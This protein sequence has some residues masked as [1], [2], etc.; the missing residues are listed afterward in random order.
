MKSIDQILWPKGAR[1][2]DDAE[3]YAREWWKQFHAHGLEKK[4]D[5]EYEP[6]NRDLKKAERKSRLRRP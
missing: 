3:Q 4:V 5:S 2:I 6:T 1:E